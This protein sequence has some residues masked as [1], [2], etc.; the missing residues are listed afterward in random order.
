MKIYIIFH[1]KSERNISEVLTKVRQNSILI[2]NPSNWILDHAMGQLII[3]RIYIDKNVM[4]KAG[5]SN[6]A[7]Q[8]NKQM[9]ADYM[10]AYKLLT[11]LSECDIAYISIT[12]SL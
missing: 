4:K 2:E 11:N 8:T 9:F 1:I 3:H 12:D 7:L 5:M 6:M 10:G